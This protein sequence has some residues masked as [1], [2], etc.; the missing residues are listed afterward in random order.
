MSVMVVPLLK[1]Q[2][3]QTYLIPL[4]RAYNPPSMVMILLVKNPVFTIQAIVS[5]ISSVVP[6][7][8]MGI[9]IHR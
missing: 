2:K 9:S 5:A 4:H 6:S 7:L 8:P 1:Q 3:F